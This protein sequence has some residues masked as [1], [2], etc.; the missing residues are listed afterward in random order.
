MASERIEEERLADLAEVPLADEE[1]ERWLAEHPDSAADLIS[2]R[3]VHALVQA[4]RD[5]EFEVPDGFEARVLARVR[6]EATLR[7]FLDL[8][9]NGVGTFL[10][11]LLA[12][13][14]GLQ[15]KASASAAA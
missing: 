9:V 5:A 2:A 8:G 10:L 11:E 1:L 7:S 3:R 6:Q 4:L 15:P 14:L 13:L 12:F